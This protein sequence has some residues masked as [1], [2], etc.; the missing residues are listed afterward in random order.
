MAHPYWPLFDLSIRTPRIELR[1]PDD[2]LVLRIID[3]STKGIHD[4]AFMPFGFAWTDKPSPLFERN[5]I[6]HYWKNRAEHQANKWG[7][8]F[9]VMLDGEPVG[10]Q[11][12][13]A[14]D[15]AMTRQAATGSWLGQAFQGQGI[16]KEMRAAVLHFAF[17][18]LDAE[19]CLS[20][21]WHDNASSLGVSRAL[22]YV[23]NGED[24]ALRRGERDRQIRL[25]LMRDEWEKRRRDDIEIVGLDACINLLVEP[26]KE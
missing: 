22:G 10:I 17:A 6:Q 15:F 9:V 26:P 4:P 19:R 21:A 14:D 7:L 13:H 8:N 18:G 12:I 5:S 2:E 23:E 1:Y 25:L 16:G 11:G 24:I 20:G 3:V